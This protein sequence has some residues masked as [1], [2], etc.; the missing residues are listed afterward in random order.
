MSIK[1]VNSFIALVIIMFKIITKYNV[2]NIGN[3]LSKIDA[4]MAKRAKMASIQKKLDAIK[5]L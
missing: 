1:K 2:Y 4:K 5:I 3:C